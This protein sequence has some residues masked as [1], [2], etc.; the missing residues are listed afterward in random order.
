[1]TALH[2]IYYARDWGF[3]RGFEAEVATELGEFMAEFDAARD[4][5]WIATRGDAILGAVAIDGRPGAHPGVRLRWFILGD[6]ARGLGI[7]RRLMGAAMDFCR[8]RRVPRVYL[9]TFA[10]LDAARHLYD[11]FGFAV[12]AEHTDTDWGAPITHQRME[13][14]L[15]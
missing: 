8:E 2:G 10:G 4:G 3:D 15:T 1:V 13:L 12:T 7:G 14:S 6:E 11:A 5:F 9:W